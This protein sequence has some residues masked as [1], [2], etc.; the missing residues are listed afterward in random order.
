MKL[1]E[2]HNNPAIMCVK[3]PDNVC[4]TKVITTDYEE[5]PACSRGAECNGKGLEC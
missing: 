5:F 1:E 3:N 2:I 4:H